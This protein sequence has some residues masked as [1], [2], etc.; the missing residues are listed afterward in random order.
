MQL[1]ANGLLS[2]SAVPLRL[3]L[4]LGAFALLGSLLVGAGSLACALLT[5]SAPSVSA[6]GVGL[7]FLGS[8]QLVCLGICGEYLH[9]I[10][11]E[12]RNRPRWIVAEQVDRTAATESRPT[13]RVACSVGGS[14]IGPI[15]PIGPM[16]N[17]T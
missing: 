7:F 17:A 4:Y 13:S 1:A 3:G 5:V 10:Y 15:R 16:R 9:R 6:L 14:P 12:V 8:V 2:Y 11:E